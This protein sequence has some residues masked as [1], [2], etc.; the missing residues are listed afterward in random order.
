MLLKKKFKQESIHG[1]QIGNGTI[2]FQGVKLN[3]HCFVVDGV[4]IDTGAKSLEKEFKR[5]FSQQ[6]ID[7]VVITHFHE[8]HTGNAAFLQKE[9]QLPVYMND[10]M[11]DYCKNEPDYPLY[12]KL[13]WGKRPPFHAKTI[14]KNFSSQ[15]ATWDVIETPG[16]AIDHL[17]FLNRETGQLF[18]G[19]LYCQERTKVVL[20]EESIPTIIQSLKK[21]L[22]YDFGDVFCCHAGYLEDGRASLQKKLDYLLELQGEIIKLYEDGVSPSQMKK[23]LFPKK[24]PII[25]FSSGEWDSLH[26][27]NSII[28]EH[29]NHKKQIIM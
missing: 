17:A 15:N 4:L 6:D 22:T 2:R 12:R 27:I 8:D 24:Y 16:H 18:T 13:F 28:Q 11:L 29:I 10:K 25:F 23:S 14:G 9:L 26:I 7:Q 1:V 5:F 19:D 3:V 20:R 21:V